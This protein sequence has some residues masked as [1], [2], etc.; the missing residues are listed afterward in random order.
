M[1]ASMKC[2][3]V[4]PKARVVEATI[5]P[6]SLKV[7]D[8]VT[9]WVG[10]V[11]SVQ[12]TP[13]RVG[14]ENIYQIDIPHLGTD[15]VT[16]LDPCVRAHTEVW[17]RESDLVSATDAEEQASR[18]RDAPGVTYTPPSRTTIRSDDCPRYED[19]RVGR[20][21]SRASYGPGADVDWTGVS[22]EDMLEASYGNGRP[23]G[24]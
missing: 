15:P 4:K 24:R 12:H 2:V 1:F 8:R 11:G 13:V 6:W 23:K 18:K 10:W 21:P 9:P 17:V 7:T 22:D 20:S 3:R 19:S 16:R 14:G 5:S